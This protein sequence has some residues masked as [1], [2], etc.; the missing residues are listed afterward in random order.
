MPY[1]FNHH[2]KKNEHIGWKKDEVEA[3]LVENEK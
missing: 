3:G 2:K 1:F